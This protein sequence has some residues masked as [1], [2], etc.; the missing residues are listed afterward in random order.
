[1]PGSAGF[2]IEDGDF[3]FYITGCN[4]RIEVLAKKGSEKKVS[5]LRLEEGIFTGNRFC[6]GR[7]LNGDE[8]MR[9]SIGPMAGVLRFEVCLY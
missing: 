9:A 3:G 5:L 6:P 4:F 1:M 8:R 7:I 2:L